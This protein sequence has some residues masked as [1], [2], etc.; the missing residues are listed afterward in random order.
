MHLKS[1]KINDGRLTAIFVDNT[2][3]NAHD[4]LNHGQ[5]FNT[6]DIQT[7]LIISSETV[8]RF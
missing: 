6:S 7:G 3:G 5:S 1:E 8:T 4:H 2:S